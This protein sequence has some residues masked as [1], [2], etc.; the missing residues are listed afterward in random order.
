[1]LEETTKRAS[2]DSVYCPSSHLLSENIDIQI[3]KF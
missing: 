3:Y 1:M 2:V